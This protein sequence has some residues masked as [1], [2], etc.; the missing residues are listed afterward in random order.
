MTLT[1]KVTSASR[2]KDRWAGGSSEQPEK[3]STADWRLVAL[4]DA[5]Y[6]EALRDVDTPPS[7]LYVIGALN[8]PGDDRAVAIV[9]SRT[10]SPEGARAA[11][12]LAGDLVVRGHTI[13]SGLAA[14]IDAA[15]HQGALD[16]TGRTIA[17]VGTGIDR[18][19]PLSNTSLRNQIAKTGAIV[20]Q[21][22]PGHPPSKTTFPAR[23][24]LIAGL[25]RVSV[26]VEFSE[27]SGTRIEATVALE[28]GKRVLLWAPLLAH[29]GWAQDFA[30]HPLV[31]FAASVD[32]IVT[33]IAGSA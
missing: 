23:N 5:D 32:D 17:V 22:T 18:T 25:S 14:G 10:P 7:H 29:L 9:G 20:S 28:Q 3:R 21:F 13:V 33:A 6:P 4:A 15:A 11:T 31:D 2:A 1:A 16:A 30:T 8:Q 12:F 26:L 27:R 19:H 24:V